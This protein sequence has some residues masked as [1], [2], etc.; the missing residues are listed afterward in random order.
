MAIKPKALSPDTEPAPVQAISIP[1]PR[2]QVLERSIQNPFG[3]PSSPVEFKD[4]GFVTHWVNTELKGGHQLQYYLQHG[5]LQAKPEYLKEPHLVPHQVSVEG[6][7]VR[8]P[9][10]GELLMYTTVE[11][12]RNRQRAKREA[13]ERAMQPHVVKRDTVEA[14][15]RHLGDEA[16]SYLNEHVGP[17]GEVV[18]K[19]ERIQRTDDGT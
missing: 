5:W 10:G 15:S 4:G 8:G 19:Y 3:I 2:I 16:A 11:H 18:D 12:Y 17:I 6:Y 9:R 7:V 1:K 13:N 14:A